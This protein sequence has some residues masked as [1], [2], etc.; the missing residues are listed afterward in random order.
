VGAGLSLDAN[1]FLCISDLKITPGNDI[2]GYFC[3]MLPGSNRQNQSTSSPL[4]YRPIKVKVIAL[5]TSDDSM[6]E[7]QFRCDI[8]NF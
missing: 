1:A 5:Q 4:G 6:S 7:F 3:A 2:F 8:N